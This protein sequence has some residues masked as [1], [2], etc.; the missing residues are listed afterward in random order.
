MS[1][2]RTKTFGPDG[3][4]HGTPGAANEGCAPYVM[5]RVLADYVEPGVSAVEMLENGNSFN[6]FGSFLLPVAFTYFGQSYTTVNASLGGGFLSFGPGLTSAFSSNPATPATYFPNGVVAPFWDQI[7]RHS[8]PEGDGALKLQR[9]PGRTIITWQ[10]YYLAS[11]ITSHLNFQVHLVDP[12]IIE[13]HYGS[14]VTAGTALSQQAPTH[15]SSATVWIEDPQG[16]LAVPFSVNEQRISPFMSGVR[17][18]PA[19]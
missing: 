14:M 17:F 2:P 5:S 8:L 3:G 15:G 4:A 6:G 1:C 7:A 18:T 16:T 12:D 19:P 10:D 9:L 13:F 11:D